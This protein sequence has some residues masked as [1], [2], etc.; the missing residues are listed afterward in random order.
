L[1]AD[2]AALTMEIIPTQIAEVKI[3]IPAKHVDYRGFLSETY[4]RRGLAEAGIELDFVQDNHSF[5]LEKGVVRGLHYQA[6][7]F[8]QD[9]LLRV[10]RGAV[11]DVA[12]DLRRNSPTFGKHVSAILSAE[13]W[14]QILVPKGF[15]H[16]FA[17]LEPRTELI[18]KVT[19]Y[20]CPEYD[21]GLFWRDPE[22]G[23]DWPVSSAAAIVS[24]KDGRLP[25][26]CELKD[27]FD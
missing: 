24:E 22:I 5:S 9:K 17:T 8:E 15:A 16:G 26:F 4:S 18:Y 3:I 19:N 12:V 11:F 6:R 14:N 7:P 10:V 23:I 13:K 27:L 1:V 20:Y 25:R 21:R 2:S